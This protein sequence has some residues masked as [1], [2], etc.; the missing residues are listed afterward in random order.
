MEVLHSCGWVERISGGGNPAKRRSGNR[1]RGGFGRENSEAQRGGV[2]GEC[3]SALD[4]YR[5]DGRAEVECLR[6]QREPRS[7]RG[8]SLVILEGKESNPL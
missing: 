2:E 3:V 4:G 1:L 8:Q 6:H 7:S 5:I